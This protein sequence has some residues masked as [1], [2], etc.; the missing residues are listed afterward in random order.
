MVG[1]STAFVRQYKY[2]GELAPTR[3]T[4]E[5][6]KRKPSED[7]NTYV[8]RWRKL[9]AKVEPPMTEEEIVRTFIKAHDLP[10]FEEIFRMIGCSFA[11]IV[12]KLE[13]FDEFV[14][15]G[16]I[17]NVSTLKMQLKALQ[18]QTNLEKKPQFKKREGE[19]T[20]VWNQD[21][22]FRLRFQ[23]YPTYSPYYPYYSNL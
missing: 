11:T 20:F 21:P 4:L 23:N 17:V 13:E 12:N 14:K 22:Y 8:K 16:K 10:Y 6:T 5:E 7:H 15:A 9:A 3:T 2:N 1:F 18:N 19:T